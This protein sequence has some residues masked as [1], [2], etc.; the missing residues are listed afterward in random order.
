M[1]SIRFI[2]F[3]GFFLSW[4]QIALPV[5][6]TGNWQTLCTKSQ[7]SSQ[8]RKM[9]FDGANLK[10]EITD[11]DDDKC[12][13]ANKHKSWMMTHEVFRERASQPL[14]KIN[15]IIKNI[16]LR[17]LTT[18]QTAK[19]NQQSYCSFS[20]W[21]LGQFKEVS[22]EKCQ[23]QRPS[24]KNLRIFNVLKQQENKLI[25]DIEQSSPSVVNR[26]ASPGKTIFYSL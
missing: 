9:S 19:L 12:L 16:H 2:L 6:L 24:N 4:P 22:F 26:P 25:L 17:P 21:E 3:V 13:K 10:Y 7:S 18:E 20:D 1:I 15:L 14:W 5:T 8:M 23:Q 11:F